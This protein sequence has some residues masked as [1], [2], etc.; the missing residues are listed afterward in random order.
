[1]ATATMPRK[2]RATKKRF[3]L[4]IGAAEMRQSDGTLVTYQADGG[5]AGNVIETE[6]DLCQKFN[7]RQRGL[8]PKFER[9]D[10]VLQ[11]HVWNP[12][13]ESLEDFSARMKAQQE[14][15]KP[16]VQVKK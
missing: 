16:Q 4:L 15:D 2:K 5:G 1:M 9:L 14:E 3:K 10:E 7:S 11:G 8:Q 12:D 13:I 6:L